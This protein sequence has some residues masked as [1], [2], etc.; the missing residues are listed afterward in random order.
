MRFADVLSQNP[1]KQTIQNQIALKSPAHAYL[2]AGA[3][4][5]GKT[6]IA[7]LIGK[8]LNCKQRKQGE[9]EPCNACTSCRDANNGSSFNLVEIDAASNRGIN[10]IKQL[11]EHV[12]YAPVGDTFKVFI[13]DE[14]HMLTTEAFNAFLKILEEP[15]AHVVF[16]LATTEIHKLPETIVSR[17][18]RFDF[19]RISIAEMACY[20]AGIAEKE[21]VQIEKEIL[22][23][24]A[25]RSEGCV[26]DAVS[27]LGQIVTLGKDITWA[28]ASLVIPRSDMIKMEEFFS[29]FA[30]KQAKQALRIIHELYNEGVDLERFNIDF[31]EFLREIFLYKIIGD[32]TAEPPQEITDA[33]AQLSGEEVKRLIK[34]CIDKIALFKNLYELPQLPLE[35]AVIEFIGETTAAGANLKQGNG[36]TSAPEHAKLPVMPHPQETQKESDNSPGVSLNISEILSLWPQIL[37]K[38]REYNHSLPVALNT[39]VPLRIDLENKRHVLYVGFK[40]KLHKEVLDNFEN[41]N[42]LEEILERSTNKKVSVKTELH[43]DI[44]PLQAPR[45]EEKCIEEDFNSVEFLVREGFSGHI[46][47]E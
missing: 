17:C 4:G 26:R 30:L 27:V 21:N 31:I 40:Y 10:E 20:L 18:Q 44:V 35:M 3:R 46:V 7:R 22:V 15:P 38:I 47:E 13:I 6:T 32:K 23:T 33:V 19:K 29:C 28:E 37:G 14:A 45:Q 39:S 34:I 11:R 42:I 43:E 12:K 2:F 25:R 36:H 41:R 1:I 9:Y 16:I 8:S 24:I 5:I